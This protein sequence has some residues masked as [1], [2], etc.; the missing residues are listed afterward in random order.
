MS[1]SWVMVGAHTAAQLLSTTSLKSMDC[2]TGYVQGVHKNLR[3]EDGVHGAGSDFWPSKPESHRASSAS[4]S[5]ANAA[6]VEGLACQ[7]AS[8][9]RRF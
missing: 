2:L 7:P 8:Q 5:T 4:Q 1:I 6:T 9:M 3:L